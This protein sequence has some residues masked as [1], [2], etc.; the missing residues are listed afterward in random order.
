[1]YTVSAVS[2]SATVINNNGLMLAH[3]SNKSMEGWKSW[4]EVIE[5]IVAV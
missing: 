5:V 3:D 1:M 2:R 4:E